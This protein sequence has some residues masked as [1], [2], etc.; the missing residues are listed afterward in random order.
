[1]DLLINAADFEFYESLRAPERRVRARH[2][3]VFLAGAAVRSG[4]T[5]AAPAGHAVSP[6]VRQED[7][8]NK[9]ATARAARTPAP[10][11]LLR[12]CPCRRRSTS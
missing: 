5:R 11:R 3:L 8:H 9:G 4:L 1:M 7:R 6:D 12:K 10:A 2:P